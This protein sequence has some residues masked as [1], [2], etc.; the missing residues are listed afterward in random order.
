MDNLARLTWPM[1][2][3]AWHSQDEHCYLDH[4]GCSATIITLGGQLC[5]YLQAAFKMNANSNLVNLVNAYV[6]VQI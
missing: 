4:Q 1:Q 5:D 6:Q 3:L 2:Q